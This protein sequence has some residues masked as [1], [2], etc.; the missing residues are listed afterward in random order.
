M[1]ARKAKTSAP[2]RAPRSRGSAKTSA[3][4]LRIVFRGLIW[5]HFEKPRTAKGA[6]WASGSSRGTLTAYLVNDADCHHA[7]HYHLPLLACIGCD[8]NTGAEVLG[9]PH[10]IAGQRLV[11]GGIGSGGLRRGC[12]VRLSLLRHQLRAGTLVARQAQ[13]IGQARDPRVG[14]NRHRCW[15]GVELCSPQRSDSPG[16]QAGEHSSGRQCGAAG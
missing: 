7:D 12:S 11:V 15:N 6:D 3:R 1:P 8:A 5:Y 14:A 2:S 4:K 13:S 10:I 16:R 9:R